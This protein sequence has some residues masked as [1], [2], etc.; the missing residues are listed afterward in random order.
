MSHDNNKGFTLIELMLSM[1][2]LSVLL[3]AIAMTVIQIGNI[4]NRGLTLKEVNQTGRALSIELKQGISQSTAFPINYPTIG[5]KYIKSTWGGRLCLGQYSYIWNYG[6]TLNNKT[7]NGTNSN[8]YSGLNQP[9]IRFIKVPD[10]TSA[11]CALP[12][13]VAINPSG[14]VELLAAGDR[15]LVVHAFTINYAAAASDPVTGQRL[16]TLSFVIG[17]NDLAALNTN[18]DTCL[19]PDQNTSDLVYCAVNEFNITARA[20]NAVQ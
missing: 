3:L 4:Y 8:I 14:A 12:T 18:A 2:F 1:T 11:Y 5:T 15:D 19:A 20:A 7:A 17:T 16:Y 10:P 6:K 13:Q 9:K